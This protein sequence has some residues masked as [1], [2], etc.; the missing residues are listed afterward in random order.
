LCAAVPKSAFD[1]LD[2]LVTGASSGLGLAIA[3]GLA[4]HVRTLRVVARDPERLAQ[5]AEKVRAAGP[6]HLVVEP[7]AIDLADP[8]AVQNL[9]EEI[10]NRPL[11]LLVNNAAFGDVGQAST[12]PFAMVA[13]MVTANSLAPA[14]L[15]HAALPHMLVRRR[16]FILTV[17]SIMTA[18]PSPGRVLYGATKGFLDIHGEGLRAELI[19]SGVIHT[20]LRPGP[21]ATPFTQRSFREGSKSPGRIDGFLSIPVQQVARAGL[22]ALAKGRASVVP[23]WACRALVLVAHL[24]PAP[25]R[26]GLLHRVLALPTT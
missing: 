10:R 20:T 13:R 8:A 5:A 2:G 21:M 15:T 9:V 23:G 6:P 22:T 19:G 3:I 12:L 25:V 16:G 14:A 7:I 11:D 24:L 1:G 18:L 17:S 26:R 4:P